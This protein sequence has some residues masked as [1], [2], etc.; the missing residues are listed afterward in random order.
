MRWWTVSSRGFRTRPTGNVDSDYN[1]NDNDDDHN[2]DDYDNNDDADYDAD[3]DD[4]NDND[5]DDDNNDS[6]SNYEGTLRK[7][8]CLV[9]C[10]RNQSSKKILSSENKLLANWI[11]SAKKTCLQANSD[12]HGHLVQD[13]RNATSW[14]GQADGP[15]AEGHQADEQGEDDDHEGGG[16]GDGDD[17]HIQQDSPCAHDNHNDNDE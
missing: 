9:S 1:S 13:S 16:D 8:S 3:Y 15:A 10:Q 2:D 4:D 6:D 12:R 11:S 14:P 17:G 7:T 5:D